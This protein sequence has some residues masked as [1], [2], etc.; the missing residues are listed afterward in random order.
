MVYHSSRSMEDYLQAMKQ[1]MSGHFKFGVERYTGFFFRNCFYVTHHAGF[2]WNRKITNQKN[3]AMG[4]VKPEENGCSIHFVR[5]RGLLCPLHFISTFLTVLPLSIIMAISRG[6]Q[7][8]P[9]VMFNICVAVMVI[10]S[11]ISTL[12][13][14]FTEKSDIGRRTLLSLLKDPADP[15]SQFKYIP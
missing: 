7:L 15:Y 1:Q 13:E 4:F 8:S 11:P 6:N 2:E 3:A 5:F 12:I 14:S 9:D 10:F